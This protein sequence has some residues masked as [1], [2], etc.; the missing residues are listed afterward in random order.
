VA[1]L[2]SLAWWDWPIER[3]T[4]HLELIVSGDMEALASIARCS[5]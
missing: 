3:I 4:Q 1:R 5:A 2:E